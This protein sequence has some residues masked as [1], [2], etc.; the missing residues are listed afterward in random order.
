MRLFV[1]VDLDRERHEAMA[2]AIDGLR[3]ALAPAGWDRAVR[4]VSPHNLHL[5]IR[6]IGELDE[7]AGARVRTALSAPLDV[8]PFDVVL[9]GAGVFPPRGAPR[10]LWIGVAGG[11]EGLARV[12]DAVESR[13][14]PAGVA[15][16]TRPFSP[17]LTI[18][19]FRDRGDRSAPRG[20]TRLE[21]AIAEVRVGAG[22]L[23]VRSITLY[24]SRLTPAGPEYSPLVSTPLAGV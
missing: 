22:P 9:E 16:E 18:G 13:L 17:H 5:T 1:A 8:P 3:R 6:F 24:Q 12:F 20:R 19:R 2:R 11:G 7:A 23:A 10:V 14:R 15:P 4:W 21:D